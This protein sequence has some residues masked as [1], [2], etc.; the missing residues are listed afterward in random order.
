[1]KKIAMLGSTGFLGKVLLN[2]AIDEGYQLKTLVRNPEKLGELKDKV[3][4]IQGNVN[5]TEDLEK[6][7]SNTEVVL[8]TV[9]PPQKNPGNEMLVLRI[10]K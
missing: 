5:S 4:F 9:G 2:K 7:L 8:S 3:D 10:K 1:M 6:T